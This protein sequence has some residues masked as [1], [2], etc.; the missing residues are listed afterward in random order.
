MMFALAVG[1]NRHSCVFEESFE[2][3]EVVNEDLLSIRVTAVAVGVS[4]MLNGRSITG[5]A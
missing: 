2:D 5:F 4:L 1:N 3:L